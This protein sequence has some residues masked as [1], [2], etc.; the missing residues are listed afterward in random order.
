MDTPGDMFPNIDRMKNIRCP[1]CII[2][3]IKDEIVPFY[4]AKVMYEKV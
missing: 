1:V 4:H 3:S 2:H